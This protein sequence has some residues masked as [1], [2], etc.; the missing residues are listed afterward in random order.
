MKT[1]I[2]PHNLK[3]LSIGTSAFSSTKIE[4]IVFEDSIEELIIGSSAFENCSELKTVK[5]PINHSEKANVRILN[6]TFKECKKLR[7]I[8][9]QNV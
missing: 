5:L 9:F 1:I 8:N 2:F 7:N 3:K 4:S 6:S